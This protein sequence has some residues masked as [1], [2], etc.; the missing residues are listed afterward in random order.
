MRFPSVFVGVSLGTRI[1]S[2]AAM[3]TRRARAGDARVV[4][5]EK[6]GVLT[7]VVTDPVRGEVEIP[8]GI[9]D[10]ARRDRGRAVAGAR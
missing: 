4:V 2:L 3:K 5:F 10:A 8:L 7:A 1:A 6:A 9:V